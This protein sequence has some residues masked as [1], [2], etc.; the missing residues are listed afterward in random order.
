M[1]SIRKEFTLIELLVVIAIIAILAGM[2][3]PALN[4]AREKA[5]RINCSANLKQMGLAVKMYTSDYSEWLPTYDNSGPLSVGVGAAANNA[6]SDDTTV[7]TN[8]VN[9]YNIMVSNK[10]LDA[11][12]I[13]VCPSMPTATATGTVLASTNID[14]AYYGRGYKESD[15]GSESAVARDWTNSNYTKNHSKYG[16]VLFGDGHVQ[17]F[18]GASWVNT[19]NFKYK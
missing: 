13:Y 16:S 6:L 10:Y 12:K 15:M 11:M 8:S 14:Y 3:L 1:K 2:L 18:S 17:G 9:D 4:A 19:N 7:A 5:R